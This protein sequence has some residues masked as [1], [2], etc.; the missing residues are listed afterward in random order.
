MPWARE[1]REELAWVAAHDDLPWVDIAELRDAASFPFNPVTVSGISAEGEEARRPLL[2]PGAFH[3][4][5]TPRTLAWAQLNMFRMHFQYL[6][7]G[8]IDTPNN[9]FAVTT[10]AKPFKD[11]F[12]LDNSNG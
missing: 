6:M 4:M 11:R 1:F 2:V 10:D 9:Y 7:A 8:E 5:L 12:G 3:E